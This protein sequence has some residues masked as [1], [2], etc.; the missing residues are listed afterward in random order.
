M[1][2]MVAQFTQPV[3]AAANAKTVRVDLLERHPDNE[4]T[5]MT[6]RY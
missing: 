3:S 1:G 6:T 4:I 5:S 2:A